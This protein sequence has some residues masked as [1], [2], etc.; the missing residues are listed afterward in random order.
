MSMSLKFRLKKSI[1]SPGMAISILIGIWLLCSHFILNLITYNRTIGPLSPTEAASTFL[2]DIYTAHALG[3]FDLF[4]PILAVLP[5]A[6]IFCDDY[7]SGYIKPILSRTSRKRYLAENILCS[8]L[9]GGLAIFIP[10]LISCVFFMMIGEPYLAENIRDGFV[11]LFEGSV[12]EKI[13]FIGG[14]VLVVV[15]L[16]VLAFIFGAVWSNVGLCIS[17]FYPNRYIALAAPFVLY[18]FLFLFCYRINVLL[19]LSPVNMLM[20]DLNTLPGLWYPF[21]Y[22]AVWLIVTLW[23]LFTGAK[24][25]LND[26]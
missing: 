11:T 6:T 2:Q 3:V 10:S 24:R 15:I 20:P 13:Q 23:L 9:A 21:V 26:V 1:L 22:Q 7:N 12:F 18:F 19:V 4:A 17:I 14:G 8:S 5:A 16:L 25:R